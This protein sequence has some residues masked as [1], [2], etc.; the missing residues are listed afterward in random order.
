MT[1]A[2]ALPPPEASATCEIALSMFA[3]AFATLP[4]AEACAWTWMIPVTAPVVAVPVPIG[5]PGVKMLTSET[6]ASP[7]PTALADW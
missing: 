7:P 2:E 3:T 6:T 4:T 5:V 1:S